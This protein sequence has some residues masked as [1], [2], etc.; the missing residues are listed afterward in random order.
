MREKHGDEQRD[1]LLVEVARVVHCVEDAIETAVVDQVF[2]THLKLV[3]H[4]VQLRFVH[5]EA[6][7]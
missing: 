7:S 4:D 1:R 6:V 5:I 3:H 2:E